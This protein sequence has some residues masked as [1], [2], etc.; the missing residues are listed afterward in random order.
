[1]FSL[2]TFR[3]VSHC[4]IFGSR[5]STDHRLTR[6]VVGSNVT[7][8]IVTFRHDSRHN[9]TANSH[10]SAAANTFIPDP[11]CAKRVTHFIASVTF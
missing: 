11:V 2:L 5:E 6:E 4:A 8:T 10:T 7:K 3:F 9:V 1:M